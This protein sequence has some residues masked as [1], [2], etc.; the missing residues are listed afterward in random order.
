MAGTSELLR[1]DR[2]PEAA[3]EADP[4]ANLETSPNTNLDAY[5]AGQKI[6]GD[7]FDAAQIEAWFADEAEGYAGLVAAAPAAS[8]PARAAVNDAAALP[9]AAPDRSPYRYG[10]HALNAHHGFDR[11]PPAWGARH[12]LA[13]G[14][15]HGHELQPHLARMADI[16]LLDA[17]ADFQ[18][19]QL[20]GRPVRPLRAQASGQIAAPD[21]SFDLITCFGVL[22]HIPNISFVLRELHRVCQPGGCALLREPITSMGDWRRP[23]LGL[24][25]RERGFPRP[26][27][28]AAIAQAGW[29][30]ERAAPCQFSPLTKLAHHLGVGVFDRRALTLVDAALAR[31]FAFNARYHRHSFW[32]R[33]APGSM[34]YVL[35]KA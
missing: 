13:F 22:H 5:F 25:Q 17:S 29:D 2:A 24:T 26:L 21:A 7:D 32:S 4:G 11:L 9:E 30:I 33:F 6:Y 19:Q 20:A 27:L 31:M 1:P 3:S 10:Y 35:R 12:V 8:G 16:T 18:P 34:F 15:A 23:R 14:S 28:E